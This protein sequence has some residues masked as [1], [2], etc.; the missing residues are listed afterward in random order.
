MKISIAPLPLNYSLPT[1]RQFY[2]EV[3]SSSFI[4]RV[5]IGEVFCPKRLFSLQSYLEFKEV[6]EQ[7]GK[8]VVFSTY[9]LPTREEDFVQVLPFIE[10]TDVIEVNNLGFLA[11]LKKQAPYKKFLVGSTC[12]LYN[13]NDFEIARDW[14][15]KGAVS[16]FDLLEETVETLLNKNILPLEVPI[17]G[18]FP[19]AFS[20]CCY[21]ARFFGKKREDC[22]LV[23]RTKTDLSLK[24]L[25]DEAAF[26]VNGNLIE[27]GQ[28]ICL[29]K[30]GKKLAKL[31][32][33]HGRLYA[34]PGEAARV[35]ELFSNYLADK[36]TLKKSMELID[37]FKGGKVTFT[38]VAW[39]QM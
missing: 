9:A 31:G 28:T 16:H 10:A 25:E 30:Q 3:A 14:G 18:R 36:V 1:L 29:F 11:F 39:R 13:I 6:L 22:E 34:G 27:S 5:C 15:S 24:N 35:A 7:A 21:T 12:S 32:A 2:E 33:S 37:S 38:P 19:L 8:E 20:W 26:V 4:D 23:C 17:Y